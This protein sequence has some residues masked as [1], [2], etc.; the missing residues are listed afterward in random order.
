VVDE[1]PKLAG[2][3][4][5]IAAAIGEAAFEYLDAP[6]GRVAAIRSAIPEGPGQFE[7]FLPSKDDVVEA[8]RRTF[9]LYGTQPVSTM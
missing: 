1:A 5:E 4:A 2:P 7:R 6:V 9:E 8:V 3:S